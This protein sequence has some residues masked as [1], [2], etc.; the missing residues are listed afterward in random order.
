VEIHEKSPV[1]K[2]YNLVEWTDTDICHKLT[3]SHLTF[4]KTKTKLDEKHYSKSN[5]QTTATAI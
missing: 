4:W 5:Q 3:I 1:T 2:I